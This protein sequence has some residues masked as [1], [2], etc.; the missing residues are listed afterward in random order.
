MSLSHK[1]KLIIPSLSVGKTKN[2]L[3]NYILSKIKRGDNDIPISFRLI[4]PSGIGKTQICYQIAEEIK[5]E[6]GNFR[7]IKIQAPIFSRDDLLI[8]FPKPDENS[9]SMLFSN[10]FFPTKDEGGGILLIDEFSRGDEQLQQVLWQIVNNY[11][12]HNRRLP[13]NWFVICTDNPDEEEYAMRYFDDAAGIRRVL[14]IYTRSSV[15]DFLKYATTRLHPTIVNYIK[16]FPQDL[17][18]WESQRR[19]AIYANPASW[20]KFSDILWLISKE[21]DLQDFLEEIEILGSGLLNFNMTRKF[22]DFLGDIKYIRPSEILTEYSKVRNDI[23][24]LDNAK[25]SDLVYAVAIHI[26]DVAPEPKTIVKN[27]VDFLTDIPIDT[28]ALF[29]TT[30]GEQE[31]MMGYLSELNSLAMRYPS[32]A[33]IIESMETVLSK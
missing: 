14:H 22:I 10:D 5:D 28:A 7:I 30:F 21:G 31:N 11:E 1:E 12:L 33:K 29:F 18:D 13:K 24:K 8:P 20:C 32:Y 23:K 4:G 17:Y 3:K 19:G 6:L 27:I 2:L 26:I 15:I 16:T 9:F 25:I